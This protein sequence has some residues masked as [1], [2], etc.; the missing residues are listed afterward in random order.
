MVLAREEDGRL[1]ELQSSSTLPAGFSGDSHTAHLDI[2]EDGR[3]IY[4]TNR[5]HDSVAVF[6]VKGDGSTVL[7]ACVDSGGRWPWFSALTGDGHMLVANNLSDRITMFR[8]DNA[9]VPHLVQTL[10]VRRPVFISPLPAQTPEP[11]ARP[12]WAVRDSSDGDDRRAECELRAVD[13]SS[14]ARPRQIDVLGHRERSLQ[15]LQ[16]VTYRC[17]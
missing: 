8:L 4:V 6:D 5:G 15:V 11:G 12:S 16:L 3:P 10:P 2:S 17:R 7:G 13:P 1:R 9:G 14:V